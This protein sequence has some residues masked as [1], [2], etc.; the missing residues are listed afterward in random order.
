M[1]PADTSRGNACSISPNR[2]G[3]RVKDTLATI[4]HTSEH[5][6]QHCA[7]SYMLHCQGVPAAC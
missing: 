3:V 1:L 4:A 6:I 7:V 2:E 5:P